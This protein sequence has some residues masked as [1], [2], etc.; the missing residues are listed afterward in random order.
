MSGKNRENTM[1]EIE[2]KPTYWVDLKNTLDDK[3]LI[4]VS[5]DYVGRLFV[6]TTMEVIEY[7]EHQSHG[8]FAKLQTKTPHDFTVLEATADYSLTYHIP[9]QYWNYHH[10]QPLPDNELL[11]VC[12]R[13][14]YWG[15]DDYDLNACVFT[16]DGKLQREFLL[17]DGIEDV[18]TTKEGKIWTSYFD[19]GI[20]GNY[21]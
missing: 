21:G 10:V 16:S 15:N 20:F 5:V 2:F 3:Q 7:R 18:Q 9:E 4:S 17:G 13:S 12:S 6:L 8:S 11:L 1:Q 14:R 19:E